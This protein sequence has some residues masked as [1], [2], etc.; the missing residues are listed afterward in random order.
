[1]E[2]TNTLAYYDTA[3]I[4]AVKSLTVQA[5]GHFE[6]FY[7]SICCCKLISQSVCH[8]HSLP[9]QS[10]ICGQGWSIPE[11]NPLLDSTPMIG[12]Q[13]C[14][15]ILDQGGSVEVTNT[16]AYYDTA[17]ITAVKS[18]TVQALGYF[19]TFYGS[20]CCCKLISQ[21]VCHSYSPPPQ[22]NIC[23]QGWSIQEEN[24]LLDSSLMVGSWSCTP[25]LDQG[26]SD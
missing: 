17:T 13:H 8:S 7:G 20:I 10:N 19:E 25:I 16:R 18:L 1:M 6:T 21:S 22:S 15:Q 11:W 23:G 12:S 5:L 24:P 3:T 14:P 4:T 9:P 26:E 2:V